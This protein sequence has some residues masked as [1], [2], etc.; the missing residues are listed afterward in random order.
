MS[1]TGK[2]ILILLVSGMVLYQFLPGDYTKIF[3]VIKAITLFIVW[4]AIPIVIKKLHK[5]HENNNF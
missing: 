1:N 3:N 2:N 5:Y 4:V